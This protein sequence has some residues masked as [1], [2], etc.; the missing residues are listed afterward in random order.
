MRKFT[1]HLETCLLV[2][3]ADRVLCHLVLLYSYTFTQLNRDSYWLILGHMALTKIQCIPIEIH[4]T[5][6]VRS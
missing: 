2:A 4:Y 3:E 5:L 1:Q 6:N